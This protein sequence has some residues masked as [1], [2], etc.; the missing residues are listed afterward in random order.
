MRLSP[1]T[2]G[3][4]SPI[5]FMQVVSDPAVDFRPIP[6]HASGDPDDH[7]FLYV[8]VNKRRLSQLASIAR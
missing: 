1:E 2:L 5:F 7:V 4:I 8:S 3:I 6:R